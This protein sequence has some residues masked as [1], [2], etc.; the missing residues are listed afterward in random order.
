MHLLLAA[1]LAAS[2]AAD[3]STCGPTDHRCTAETNVAAARAATTDSE[4]V[5]RLYR[6]H[7]AYLALARGAAPAEREGLLCRAEELL[8]QA[9]ALPPPN[10]LRQPLVKTAKE[11]ADALAGIDCSP[12]KQRKGAGRLVAEGAGRRV[13]KKTASSAATPTAADRQDPPAASEPA[14]VLLG[15]RARRPADTSRVSPSPAPGPVAPDRHDDPRPDATPGPTGSPT[16]VVVASP[17][18]RLQIGGGVAMVAG[19]ALGGVATY[20]G[21]R[22]ARAKQAGV[23]LAATETGAAARE[24]GL[25]LQDE[26][27]TAGT[28]GV[29]VGVVGG[30]A[31]LAG[32]TMLVVGHQ[33]NARGRMREAIVMPT[34]TGLLLSVNF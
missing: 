11:I 28:I 26:Y 6:A 21:T 18:R 33:R 7:R 16:A 19:A 2:P 34:R 8:D 14:S 4:R 22:A 12:K 5:H 32:I 10:S 29:G 25:A 27:R 24:E 17:G 31:L 30:A 3:P 1:T 23:D 13:A 15:V 9:Q 20:L